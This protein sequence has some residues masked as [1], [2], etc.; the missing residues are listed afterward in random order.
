MKKK[1]L[2]IQHEMDTPPGTTLEWAQL[3][4][5]ECRFWYPAQENTPPSMKDFAGVVICGGSMDTF[6]EEKFPWLK[7]EKAF[8]QEALDK[9]MKIFGLC[10]GSQL[11]AELFGG[12]V[13]QHHGWEIGFIP[14]KTRDGR[15]VPMFQWHHCTFELPPNAELLVQG[16]YCRNQAFKVGDQVIATQF[17][18]EAT[19]EWIRECAEG[20]REKH[21]GNV[22]TPE[23]ILESMP[24]RK[25]LQAWYFEQLDQLFLER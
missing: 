10:L 9:K 22:Q 7:T 11:L 20:I 19:E 5:F 6:E 24:L 16:D 15:E 25:K 14:A 18:P 2:V 23:S 1:L 21:Q 12:R 4:G 13:Y 3:R 17:H 8:L